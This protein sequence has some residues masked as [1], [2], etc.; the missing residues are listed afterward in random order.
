M[1]ILIDRWERRDNADRNALGTAAL[2]LCRAVRAAEG[3]RSARFYWN[4]P[5]AIALL[6]D[7]ESAE[8]FDRPPTQPAARAVFALADL[9]RNT[10]SERWS[11]PGRAQETYRLA[12][13]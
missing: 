1:A 2:D 10:G 7:A 4:G 6:W 5:D 12:G 8:V 13:R 11:E 9:A 3:T